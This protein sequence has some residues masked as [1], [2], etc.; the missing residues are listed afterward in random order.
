MDG[1]NAVT[2][3][4]HLSVTVWRRSRS[5][6]PRMASCAIGA[7]RSGTTRPSIGS[8]ASACGCSR[9]ERPSVHL[10][11]HIAGR[12]AELAEISESLAALQLQG[13]SSQALLATSAPAI[14]ERIVPVL[15]EPL[16][17]WDARCWVSRVGYSDELGCEL[18]R[19]P[20]D[21]ACCGS[22]RSPSV[23]DRTSWQ[24]CRVADRGRSADG[25]RLT[26]TRARQ[27]RSICRS[28]IS[29]VPMSPGCSA[30]PRCTPVPPSV[31]WGSRRLRST[32]ATPPRPGR[33]CSP[34]ACRSAG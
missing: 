33:P 15:S 14:A 18:S 26:F 7:G 31:R 8:S 16:E 10:R 30:A 6:R 3:I 19:A 4:E 2:A 1:P 24:R 20:D 21:A 12:P 32:D 29:S 9:R 28:S 13:A 23:H 11:R 22:T 34:P 25:R 27:A 17:I 5:A